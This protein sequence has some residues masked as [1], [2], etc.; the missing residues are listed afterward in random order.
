[1]RS[2]PARATALSALAVLAVGLLA[3]PPAIA[4]PGS[5][6]AS[7]CTVRTQEVDLTVD[8]EAR[9]ATAVATWDIVCS[10]A[11]LLTAETNVL[12]PQRA[13]RPV[14]AILGTRFQ[15]QT[16]STGPVDPNDPQMT[17]TLGLKAGTERLGQE[18][19]R[20]ATRPDGSSSCYAAGNTAPA[21]PVELSAP[22]FAK[23]ILEQFGLLR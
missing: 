22:D 21:Q 18:V 20:C 14:K 15:G 11:T 1:M 5:A 7:D 4:A 17:A 10:S 12:T 16:S 8:R 23:T 6:D 9:T 3:A 19:R 13:N 2:R